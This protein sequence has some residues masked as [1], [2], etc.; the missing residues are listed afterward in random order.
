MDVLGL[1][2]PAGGMAGVGGLAVT[3][4]CC[5]DEPSARSGDSIIEPAEATQGSLARPQASGEWTKGRA[6][7]HGHGTPEARRLPR[8]DDFGYAWPNEFGIFCDNVFSKRLDFLVFNQR[9][10]VIDVSRFHAQFNQVVDYYCSIKFV[11]NCVS[12]FYAFGTEL[13]VPVQIVFCPLLFQAAFCLRMRNGFR[14]DSGK[15]A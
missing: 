2:L 8:Q 11:R 3:L 1:G 7:V 6:C 12:K 9:T 10:R 5:S 4:R 15:P 14:A 13:L